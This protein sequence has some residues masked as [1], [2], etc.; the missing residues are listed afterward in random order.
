MYNYVY[1]WEILELVCI[2]VFV[3]VIIFGDF[4]VIKAV[5]E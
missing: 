1:G 4:T 5:F 3:F 2:L